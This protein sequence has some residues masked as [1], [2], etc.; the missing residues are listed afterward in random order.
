MRKFAIVIIVAFLLGGCSKGVNSK[1]YLND[2]DQNIANNTNGGEIA[3][4][5]NY[6]YFFSQEFQQLSR[7]KIGSTK[8]EPLQEFSNDAKDLNFLGNDLI[9][10]T[11]Y[12]KVMFNSMGGDDSASLY[13]IGCY[14]AT[15]GN[16]SLDLTVLNDYLNKTQTVEYQESGL[17]ATRGFEE[18]YRSVYDLMVYDSKIFFA[19]SMHFEDS[20]HK[21]VVGDDIIGRIVMFD[22]KTKE[23][24]SIGWDGFNAG[25][26][27]DYDVS[28]IGHKDFSG[29][30]VMVY[31]SKQFQD[32]V[33]SFEFMYV[34]NRDDYKPMYPS[35]PY[36]PSNESIY[37]GQTYISY[38]DRRTQ[39]YEPGT[40][41]NDGTVNEGKELYKISNLVPS[42]FQFYKDNVY[43]NVYDGLYVYNNNSK[44]VKK[45]ISINNDYYSCNLYKLNGIL[46]C[47]TP[48]IL[49]Y[50]YDLVKNKEITLGE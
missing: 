4:N 9:F 18:M 14:G 50:Q 38:S 43:L 19:E 16:C 21:K 40:Y 30:D 1:E 22:T 28:L 36:E 11:S 39:N 37:N 6:A 41:I 49:L 24:K 5:G 46:Y 13:T 10:L 12:M 7:F 47:G 25:V 35:F 31:M 29:E 44:E 33:F 20:Y 45:L 8:V 42:G 3:V 27:G 15:D 32:R 34:L 23:I 48:D 26:V 2:V 17:F